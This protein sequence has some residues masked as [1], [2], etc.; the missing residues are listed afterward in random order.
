[1]VANTRRRSDGRSVL[2]TKVSKAAVHYQNAPH[3]IRRCDNCSMFVPGKGDEQAGCTL[4]M[5]TIKP[6]GYCVEW[7]KK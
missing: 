7:D 4:V 3:G 1:M 2:P 5:G 6:Y